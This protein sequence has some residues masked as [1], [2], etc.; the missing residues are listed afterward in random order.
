MHAWLF[1]VGFLVFPLWW[2]AGFLL[3]IPRTRKVGE[4][5]VEKG[6]VLDDPQVE[7]GASF[8]CG[9]KEVQILI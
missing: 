1:F 8:F 4:S 7:F 2:I 5:E 6:V 9:E 3:P